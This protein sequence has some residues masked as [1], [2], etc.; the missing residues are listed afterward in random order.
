MLD[1]YVYNNQHETARIIIKISHQKAFKINLKQVQNKNI[2][3]NIR[4]KHS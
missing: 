4:L 1:F 3:K 2:N